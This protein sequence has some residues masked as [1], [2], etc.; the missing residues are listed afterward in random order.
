MGKRKQWWSDRRNINR[1]SMSRKTKKSIRSTWEKRRERESLRTSKRCNSKSLRG[2]SRHL[3]GY[4]ETIKAVNTHKQLRAWIRDWSFY[5]NRSRKPTVSCSAANLSSWLKGALCLH[6]QR[7]LDLVIK[8][9]MIITKTIIS[10]SRLQCWITST[11]IL[12]KAWTTKLEHRLPIRPRIVVNKWQKRWRLTQTDNTWGTIT[13]GLWPRY[14]IAT[15]DSSNW[16]QISTRRENL[17]IDQLRRQM[18]ILIKCADQ[19]KVGWSQRL[20]AGRITC[21]I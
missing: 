12:P 2:K 7:I 3:L 10:S 17:H 1:S 16:I 20:D 15:I 14:T 18:N 5:S 9:T 6:L 19:L 13:R 4:N 8:A 21:R 11:H